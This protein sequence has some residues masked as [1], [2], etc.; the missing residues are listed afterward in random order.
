MLLNVGTT[1]VVLCTVIMTGVTVRR[2]FATPGR[3]AAPGPQPAERLAS[4]RD[5]SAVGHRF[6]P[7]DAELTIVV[8]SDFE[9]PMCRTFATRTYPTVAARYPGRIALLYRHWPLRQ[10]R[11]A[12]PAARASECAAAQGRFQQFHDLLYANQ[13]ML[14][15]RT[16]QQF[17]AEAGI[18]DVAA[19]NSCYE[20]EESVPA[21]E[22]D[23]EAVARIGG[24]G[25]PT[26]VVNGWLLRGGASL[27]MLDSIAAEFLGVQGG[28]GIY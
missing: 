19:F 1:L 28:T 16:F 13:P 24:T 21:I 15:L 12:Y 5:I 7:P 2:E 23:I 14:G 22:R 8:F 11:F 10:H 3:R 25:T 4:W 9:C 6:G 17:A 27:Q 20:Q 26:V 18:R